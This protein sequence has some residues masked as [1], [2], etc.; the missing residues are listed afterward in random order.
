MDR[1]IITKKIF[2]TSILSIIFISIFS[3]FIYS[4]SI[5]LADS[6]SFALK[7]VSIIEKSDNANGSIANN[8]NNIIKNN[9]VFHRLNDYVV[10]KLEISNNT[11]NQITINSIEDNN[12]D[13]HIEYQ[14]NL[15]DDLIVEPNET[16]EL[17]IKALYKNEQADLTK[18]NYVNSVDFIITYT[19]N[20]NN[21][22]TININP[23][24]RDNIKTYIIVLAISSIG[25]TACFL[26]GKRS[27]NKTYSNILLFTLLINMCIP[28]VVYAAT[29]KTTFT[30]ETNIGLYD[31]LIVTS[32]VDGSEETII[33]S[34]DNPVDGLEEPNIEGYNFVGWTYEDGTDYN[35]ST[36]ITSDT[37]IVAKLE[38]KQYSITFNNNTSDA[39]VS[40]SM[41]QQTGYYGEE[42][43]INSNGFTRS[44]YKFVGWNTEAD[45]SGTQYDN[46]D[47]I[48]LNIEGPITLYA[49]W[50]EL[51]ANL[52]NGETINGLIKELN[53]DMKEFKKSNT[54]PDLDNIE[55]RVIST[56]NSESS[57][58][59]WNDNDIIY[60]WSEAKIV[61]MNSD[62]SKMFYSLTK[63]TNVDFTSLDSS[64]V[65]STDFMFQYCSSLTTM[66]L[67]LDTSNVTSMDAMFANCVN[68]TSIDF[69]HVDLSNV[70]NFHGLVA[71][72]TKLTNINLENVNVEGAKNFES[73]FSTLP[74]L[75][76]IDLSDFHTPN[77]ESIYF[78][79]LRCTNLETIYATDQLDISNVTDTRGPLNQATSIVGGAGT[80]YSVANA[81]NVSYFR[82]DDPDNGKPGYLTLKNARYI[83]Y[84]SNGA[85]GGDKMTSHYLTTTNPGNLKTNTYTKTGST[86]VGWNTKDDG[87][88]ESYTDGQLM[89]NLEASKTPLT[90]YAQ[91]E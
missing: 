13:Q 91:W 71:G 28:I 58:Y 6:G 24:T 20:N 40:G 81:K 68:L 3:L 14:Y 8:D 34:Y 30:L 22:G 79:F 69:T 64:Q 63:L 41:D 72:C 31:K 90:L 2:N 50:V 62:S 84:N 66:D 53:P 73:M 17:N 83:R 48:N 32:V 51:Q 70:Q 38:K 39:S 12:N 47:L 89:S 35:P 18:R 87:T 55:Y 10:Y 75:T 9:I 60:W 15:E 43:N 77:L 88:G 45:G 29:L 76:E 23:N 65:T 7:D 21:S 82:I 74:N 42:M 57:V 1:R 56:T 26:Y 25:L 61:Y 19:D 67:K 52:E 4:S 54:A 80:I 78:M 86:F 27:N 49:Q 16:L 44:G 85:D 59:I 46:N 37:K 11:N 5:V 33:C 36:P